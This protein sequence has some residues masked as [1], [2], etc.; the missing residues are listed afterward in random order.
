MPR[1][2]AGQQ[3]QSRRGMDDYQGQSILE[4][5]KSLLTQRSIFVRWFKYDHQEMEVP[6][7][8]HVALQFSLVVADRSVWFT[9]PVQAQTPHIRLGPQSF[10]ARYLFEQC[11]VQDVIVELCKSQQSTTPA[12]IPE[13]HLVHHK[14]Q[15]RCSLQPFDLGGKPHIAKPQ[16]PLLGH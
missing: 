10:A 7:Q 2:H 11:L 1:I 14:S 8:A 9:P 5:N 15:A 6:G 12:G 4:E 16:S 13:S 3:W